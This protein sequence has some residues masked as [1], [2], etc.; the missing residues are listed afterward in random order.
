M[1][2]SAP[3]LDAFKQQMLTMSDS[4]KN[5]L[6][7]AFNAA[8][9]DLVKTVIKEFPDRADDCRKGYNTFLTVVQLSAKMPINAMQAFMMAPTET[10]KRLVQYLD[11]KDDRFFTQEAA[12]IPF[13]ADFKFEQLWGQAKEE[14]KALL[15]RHI[16]KVANLARTHASTE[17]VTKPATLNVMDDVMQKISS[18]ATNKK[19]D[20]AKFDIDEMA[21]TV[22]T[23]MGIKWSAEH[24]SKLQSIKKQAMEN[25]PA[26]LESVMPLLAKL[27][28]GPPAE[29]GQTMDDLKKQFIAKLANM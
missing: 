13:L 15:W 19:A 29:A 25:L 26:Q 11:A 6:V 3:S 8:I 24:D 14:Q 5:E 23:Q 18:F 21:K 2:T 12:S 17:E 20:D 9:R 1:T 16:T 10:S 7:N 28:G 4:L 22:A 27:T